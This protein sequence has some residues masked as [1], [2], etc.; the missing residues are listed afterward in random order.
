MF[1]DIFTNG[2]PLIPIDF[3]NQANLSY[4]LGRSLI[5]P[6]AHNLIQ[7]FKYERNG[8]SESLKHELKMIE[9]L[10]QDLSLPILEAGI[11]NIEGR[12]VLVY[13]AETAYFDYIGNSYPWLSKEERIQRL[14]LMSERIFNHLFKLFKQKKGM[15][16]L[17]YLS[18]YIL[19]GE[20]GNLDLRHTNPEGEISV[21]EIDNPHL[22]LEFANL[23]II[24]TRD[25]EHI[26]ELANDKLVLNNLFESNTALV[27]SGL[28]NDLEDKEI[29][30]IITKELSNHI[31]N[32]DINFLSQFIRQFGLDLKDPG[33]VFYFQYTYILPQLEQLTAYIWKNFV[34]KFST[35]GKELSQ[36]KRKPRKT[37]SVNIVALLLALFSFSRQNIFENITSAQPDKNP[38]YE[39]KA[40]KFLSPMKFK[41]K[42]FAKQIL[43]S[44]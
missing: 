11:I 41:D 27:Y 29:K 5:V 9:T 36:T 23:G 18:H 43:Q 14:T 8:D 28:V 42:N 2:K 33:D 31:P 12:T 3:P 1:K 22:A 40:G 19:R 26:R 7:V 16:S 24:G 4:W 37:S 17:L 15:E 25:W 30:K 34:L 39:G 13:T 20:K 44:L 35:T 6:L 38:K 21:G 10:K 32:V